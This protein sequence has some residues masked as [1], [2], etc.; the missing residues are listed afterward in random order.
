MALRLG[1]W[2]TEI[3]QAPKDPRA[4]MIDRDHEGRLALPSFRNEG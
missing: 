1:G 4:N 2:Q 3:P